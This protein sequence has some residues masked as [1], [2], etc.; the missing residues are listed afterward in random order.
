MDKFNV[1]DKFS[2]NPDILTTGIGEE[3]VMVNSVTQNSYRINAI[4]AEIWKALDKDK[5]FTELLAALM[6]QYNVEETACKID[7]HIFLKEMVK[8]NIIFH[9]TCSNS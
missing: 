8:L 6:Q 2:R 9:I 7:L 1:T 3:I 4:G 5:T